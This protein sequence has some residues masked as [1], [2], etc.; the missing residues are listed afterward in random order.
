MVDMK[1]LMYS[2]FSKKLL[3]EKMKSPSSMRNGRFHPSKCKGK[4]Q[5]MGVVYTHSPKMSSP[6]PNIL[7][8]LKKNSKNSNFLEK[9]GP[10]RSLSD[11]G[12]AAD[13]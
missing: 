5:K 13:D 8:K 3:K 11:C 9:G 12:L 1:V 10:T 4:V 6:S 2:N 7:R